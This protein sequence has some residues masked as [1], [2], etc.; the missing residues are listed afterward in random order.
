MV[1]YKLKAVQRT[2]FLYPFL[3]KSVRSTPKRVALPVTFLNFP[4]GLV[5]IT[6][7]AHYRL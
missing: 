5:S 1:F 3:Q 6:V 4:V 2:T 7:R